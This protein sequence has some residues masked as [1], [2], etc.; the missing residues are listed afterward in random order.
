MKKFRKIYIAAAVFAGFLGL[1]GCGQAVSA[2]PAENAVVFPDTIHIQN[3][4][5]NVIAVQSSETVKVVPDMA[6]LRFS[7]VT[8]ET[9]AKTCQDKNNQELTKVIQFLKDFGIAEESLQTSNYGM[10]P[11][12]DWNSGRT[13]TGYEMETN[14]IVSDVSIEQTGTLLSACVE[15]GINNIDRVSYLSSQYDICYQEALSKAI[16]SARQKAQT[17]AQASGCTLG[18][19]VHVEEYLDSQEARYNSYTSAAGRAE[20][21]MAFDDMA[22][23]PGQLSIE[24]RIS[25]EFSIKEN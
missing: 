13:I 6:E 25:V 23:E 7:V 11:I 22:V 4:K 9:D 18:S 16:E 8:Q 17:I 2:A 12:Y 15:A 1:T 24:A 14:L 20:K 5:Q 21:M 10:Q 3:E 19:V